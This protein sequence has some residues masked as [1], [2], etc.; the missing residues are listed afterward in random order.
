MPFLPYVELLRDDEAEIWEVSGEEGEEEEEEEE[1]EAQIISTTEARTPVIT[2]VIRRLSR[3]CQRGPCHHHCRA[4]GCRRDSRSVMYGFA[5]SRSSCN[6]SRVLSR[7]ERAAGS[8]IVSI[9]REENGP[10]S[11]ETGEYG[12]C[13]TELPGPGSLRPISCACTGLGLNRPRTPLPTNSGVLW[14]SESSIG[15]L[16]W[17]GCWV[18]IRGRTGRIFG[19]CIMEELVVVGIE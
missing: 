17:R 10:S 11:G 19:R 13:W 16:W 8:G 3:P 15:G 14:V 2:T 7:L 9:S 6:N 12:W 5:G 18:V 1:G 4:G